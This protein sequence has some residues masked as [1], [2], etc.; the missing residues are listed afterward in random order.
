[1]F[2]LLMLLSACGTE[3]PV[4]ERKSA[5]VPAGVDL[6]GHWQ[7]RQADADTVNRISE[8]ERKAAG[9]DEGISLVPDRNTRKVRKRRSDGVE[10][11]RSLQVTQ[12]SDGLFIS[13]DRSVVEEYRFGEQRQVNVGPVQ[14]ERVSGWDGSTYVIETLDKEGAKLIETYRLEDAGRTL[15]RTIWIERK[16][17]N[18]LDIAQ[19]FDRR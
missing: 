2:V 7:L 11:G 18:Q 15:Q 10:T 12:T 13:F 1:M 5:A 6:S 14:A 17:R 9:G 19:A 3:G 16:D 4:L 8:A